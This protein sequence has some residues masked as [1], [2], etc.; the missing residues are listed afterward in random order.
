[1]IE[2]SDSDGVEIVSEGAVSLRVGGSLNKSSSNSSIVSSTPNKI[3][4]KQGV[5]EM[6]LGGD[7][8]LS[9]VQIKLA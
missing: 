2:L 1:M 9:G 7:L 3:R 6:N 5:T 8:N 4:L